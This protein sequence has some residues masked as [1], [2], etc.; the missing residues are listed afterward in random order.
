MMSTTGQTATGTHPLAVSTFIGLR[1]RNPKTVD[2]TVNGF[3]ARFDK[4]VERERKEDAPLFVPARFKEGAARKAENVEAVSLA[5]LDFDDGHAWEDFVSVW[6]DAGYHFWIYTTY[7][8][9]PDAPRWRAVFPLE[10]AVIGSDWARVWGRVSE[11]LAHGL[12]DQACK[13]PGRMYFFPVVPM[14]AKSSYHSE[15]HEGRLL[16]LSDLPEMTPEVIEREEFQR[17]Q[18]GIAR[19]RGRV[20]DE[21]DAKASWSEILSGWKY[22]GKM[23][24]LDKWVRPGKEGKDALSATTGYRTGIGEDRIYCFSS[25]T[26]LPVGKMLSKFA[27]YSYL[28]CGGDFKDAAR[29]LAQQGYSPIIQDVVSNESVQSPAEITEEDLF[30]ATSDRGNALRFARKYQSEVVFVPEQNDWGFWSGKR[31]VISPSAEARVNILMQEC[32]QSLTDEAQVYEDKDT[33]AA[34]LKHAKGSLSNKSIQAAKTL[35]KSIL[36]KSISEFD[37]HPWLLNTQDGTVDLK[38]GKI[39]AHDP[40]DFIQQITTCGCAGEYDSAPTFEK[41]LTRILPP[42]GESME[43]AKF[44]LSWLGYNL[45]G[46][47]KEQCF[48][49]LYGE[50][51]NG[52]STLIDLINWM[53]GDYARPMK[54]EALMA[55]RMGMP[56]STAEYELAGLRGRR[57]VTAEE[58]GDGERLNESLIKQ[59]TGGD[60][61][62]AR[63][64]YGRPFSYTPEFKVTLTGNTK[65]Q[66]RGQ[67][68]AIWRRV[69]LIHFDQTITDNERI[70]DLNERLRAEASQILSLLVGKCLQWQKHGLPVPEVIKQDV[71]A[72]K[73][74]NDYMAVFIEEKCVLNDTNEVSCSDLHQHYLEWAKRTAAPMLNITQFGRSMISRKGIERRRDVSGRKVYRGVTKAVEY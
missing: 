51:R 55:S 52:K 64:P 26:R 41:Y 14:G 63:H 58:A 5:V 48:V 47:N 32:L 36:T 72:Y 38:T 39:K 28:E 44:L 7:K 66:I 24:T 18:E 13:D 33:R 42:E 25:S 35:A 11:H 40:A 50:G 1:D 73:E 2:T 37:R 27:A 10:S 74:E 67:D 9:T 70:E 71:E 8:H 65:P 17:E 22:A 61:V 15:F 68:F 69:R 34:L 31:W 20:G 4:P 3:R 16:S 12:C 23:G 53:L 62:N 21:Y 59:M 29:R 45:T 6:K 54:T 57:F 46:E 49:M 43:R 60:S 56:S 30:I 19:T